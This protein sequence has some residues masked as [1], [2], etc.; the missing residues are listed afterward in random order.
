MAGR[1]YLG[2]MGVFSEE[3]VSGMYRF[4]VGDLGGAYYGWDVQIAFGTGS[5]ADAYS[6]IGKAH[7]QGIAVYLGVDGDSAD[8]K[9]TAGAND[10]QRYLS[11]ISDQDFRKH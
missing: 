5:L 7:V 3:P 11:T 10:A 4:Y 1:A 9:L 8:A 2:K 6:F